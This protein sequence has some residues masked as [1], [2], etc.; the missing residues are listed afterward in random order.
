M[1]FTYLIAYKI[2]FMYQQGKF[3]CEYA[4]FIK[5]INPTNDSE[6]HHRSRS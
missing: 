2:Y 1:L 3:A 6:R 5:E 4:G